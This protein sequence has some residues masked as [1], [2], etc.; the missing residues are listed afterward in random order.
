MRLIREIE[1]ADIPSL[2]RVRTATDENRLSMEDLAALDINAETVKEKL[3]GNYKGWLC[4]EDGEVVGFAMG[5]K[6]SGELWVIAVLP[7]HICKGIGSQLLKQVENWL[8]STGYHE[9]WLV[10]GIS[11]RLRAYSF[12]RKH[13]W[14]DWKIENGARYMMKHST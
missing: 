10:T 4:E 8:F 12:Y 9:L 1:V 3:L 11:E 2:F 5:D 14:E 6:S 7:S 13:G